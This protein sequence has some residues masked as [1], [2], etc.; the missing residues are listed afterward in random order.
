MFVCLYCLVLGGLALSSLGFGFGVRLGTAMHGVEGF[1]L[2]KL[3]SILL[4]VVWLALGL[5]L[6]RRAFLRTV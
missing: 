3:A 1:G 4:L 5:F 2:S 6:I